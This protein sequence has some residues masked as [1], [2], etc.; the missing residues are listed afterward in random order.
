[1]RISGSVLPAIG[2]IAGPESLQA[3]TRL[4]LTFFGLA[5]ERHFTKTQREASRDV[6]AVEHLTG[7]VAEIVRVGVARA[8]TDL[9][10]P[11]EDILHI[12]E[13]RQ[14]TIEEVAAESHVEEI[15]RLAFAHQADGR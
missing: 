6:T 9:G 3:I 4:V 12:D 5:F 2:P 8:R 15:T 11:V 1:M 13:H 14:A 7:A 10:T